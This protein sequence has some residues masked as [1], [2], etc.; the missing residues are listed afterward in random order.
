[1]NGELAA[2]H[3][4]K[5]GF[6]FLCIDVQLTI[7]IVQSRFLQACYSRTIS[8]YKVGGRYGESG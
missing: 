3:G 7:A 6:L 1:M 5:C 2:R 4:V 8:I